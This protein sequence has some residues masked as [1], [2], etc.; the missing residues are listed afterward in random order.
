MEIYSPKPRGPKDYG[1]YTDMDGTIT[2]NTENLQFRAFVQT[3]KDR[4]KIKI[5]EP[6]TDFVGMSLDKIFTG[7]LSPLGIRPG[8]KE[9]KELLDSGHENTIKVMREN[10][11]YPSEGLNEFLVYVGKPGLVTSTPGE[12]VQVILKKMGLEKSFHPVVTKDET[13]PGKYKPEPDP[14]IIAH[15][16]SKHSIPRERCIAIEDSET[17]VRS[18]VSAKMNCIGYRTDHTD[19][20]SLE[21][22][23]A[24]TVISNFREINEEF[25]KNLGF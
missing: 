15:E 23:G 20:D 2:K 3:A 24:F 11:I 16:R 18:A 14:Y 7:L 4:Y 13:P 22:A 1:W 19:P 9:M 25:I 8:E 21:R 5:T 6:D 17:G 10:E 12:I